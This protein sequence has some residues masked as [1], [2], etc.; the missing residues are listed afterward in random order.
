[1]SK[2]K[3]KNEPWNLRTEHKRQ[4]GKIPYRKR[5]LICTEG[6][7]EA[8]YFNHYK[9]STGPIIVPLDKS[10]HKVNLVKK[11]IKEKNIR[12]ANQ[13]FDEAIDEAW[14]VLDRDADPINQLDKNYFNQTLE[15]AKE[16]KISVAYSNDAFELW[17]L[18]HYQDLKTSTHRDQLCKML[19]K[20]IGVKYE[21]SNDLYQKIKDSRLTALKRASDLLKLHSKKPESANH[22]TT[23]HLLVNKLLN[24]PG[25]REE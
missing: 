5:Y 19:S 8:L 11:T 17:V 6:K 24:E 15:I 20:H 3:Q 13:E 16:H 4:K 25:Y 7:T 23:I 22:S 9:S 12:I 10:D 14:V 2:L 18:L 1:M 21:K